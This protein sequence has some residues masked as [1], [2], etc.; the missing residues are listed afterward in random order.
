MKLEFKRDQSEE[1]YRK[2]LL[3]NKLYNS[4]NSYSKIIDLVFKEYIFKQ[5]YCWDIL[6][7]DK[8]APTYAY[9]YSVCVLNENPFPEGEP[10]IAKNPKH[11]YL[12]AKHILRDRFELCEPYLDA[13]Y[14]S[15]YLNYMFELFLNKKISRKTYEEIQKYFFV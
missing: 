1:Y 3:L 14:K 12:Y 13:Y 7:K 6:F 4:N 8:M 2:F 9:N 10:Y 11:A 15:L 5:G